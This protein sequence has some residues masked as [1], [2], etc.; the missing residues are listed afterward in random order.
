MVRKGYAPGWIARCPRCA[1]QVDLESLGWMRIGA[2]SWGKRRPIY[3]PEC[4]RKR[5]MYIV[6]VDESGNPNQRLGKVLVMVF[7]LQ[8]VIAAIVVGIL[9]AVGVIPSLW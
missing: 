4:G 5:W 1:Y 6:H 7:L 8:A 2:Y 9:M 3:C